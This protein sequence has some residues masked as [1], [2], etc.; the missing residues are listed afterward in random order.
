MARRIEEILEFDEILRRLKNMTTSDLGKERID[1]LEMESDLRRIEEMQQETE[2]ALGLLMKRSSPP[3][4][5]IKG[6]SKWALHASRG[7]VLSIGEI[8]SIGDFLRGVRRIRKYM[9]DNDSDRESV[10]P[11]IEGHI[12]SLWGN[13][14]LERWIEKTIENEESLYDDA[15]PRLKQI[16]RSLSQK[17]NNIREKLNS[18]VA[19]QD[20]KGSLQDS[21]ITMREGRYV[22]PVRQ[23]SRGKIPGL[24]HDMS[25]SGQTVYIE[26][27]AVVELNNEIR[28]LE[29]S[30]REEIIR[31]LTEISE[32]IGQYPY[33]F[34][35]D[36][37]IMA[38]LDF[39]FAKGKLAL[40]QNAIRPKFSTEFRTKLV[41][42]RHPLLDPKIVVPVTIELGG[43]YQAL[44]ITGPNTGGKTVSIKT[45]G[46]LTMMAQFGLHI[47]ARSGSVVGI[48]KK[49]FADIGDEQSIEQSLS[50]FSSHMV[51]IVDIL[52]EADENSLVL[53]DELGAGTDPTEGAALAL[54]I[55]DTLKEQSIHVMATTHYNQL[56]LYALTEPGVQN[57]SMEF[58]IDTLSPT[59]RLI[60]GVPGKSNAFEI[61]RR[62][63]LPDEIIGRAN[64][65]LE[66]EDIAFEDVLEEL[67]NERQRLEQTRMRTEEEKEALE[68]ELSKTRKQSAAL[69]REKDR[70]LEKARK[71]AKD[72]VTEA[73]ENA[74]LALSEIKDITNKLEKEEAKTLQQAQDLLRSDLKRLK[75]SD[76]NGVVLKEASNPVKELKLGDTVFAQ[77]LGVEATVLALEDAK[78]NVLVQAG[79]MKMS[80]PKNT[81]VQASKTRQEE[82]RTKNSKNLVQKKAKNAKT[83]IDIRGKTFEECVAD[84]DKMIDDAY[85]TNL[86]SVRIIH[87]KGTG[88]LRQK[89]QE[90][91]RKHKLVKSYKEAAYDDGGSGVTYGELK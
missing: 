86:K 10:Y 51:H 59:Y 77:S 33:E 41:E 12:S 43:D 8:L 78:G 76:K 72:L 16:R 30:E 84:L 47:P 39:L 55:I 71:E 11:I 27:M 31:I 29:I 20:L 34:K 32:E 15:S 18:I 42:A 75:R 14:E 9:S 25:S 66:T 80:L 85:L 58:D 21:I 83:E 81:L 61:S 63:G 22:V 28:E 53:F 26:P 52:K 44:I 87:G 46:L 68:K 23:D 50:T 1:S 69:E 48:Y 57:A 37:Q 40:E 67:E 4:I 73:K 35:A 49:I 89:V 54:S 17:K 64:A 38:E 88:A 62:L 91:L 7:G 90:Y 24:V 36:E 56:K 79:L 82:R 19:N 6:V 70:I 65:F 3:L 60:I 74:E 5:G 2:E 45:L 13:V